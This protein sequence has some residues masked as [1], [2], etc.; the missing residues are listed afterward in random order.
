MIDETFVH[1]SVVCFGE[2]SIGASSFIGPGTVIYGPALIGDHVYIGANSVIGAAAED[3]SS[4]TTE[5]LI[6]WSHSGVETNICIKSLER[7]EKN[8][9]DRVVIGSHTIIRESCTIHS[10]IGK[11]TLIG[12]HCFIHS[13]SGIDHDCNL[14]DRVVL[15]PGVTLAGNVSLGTNCQIGLGAGV[16]QGV[17]VGPYAMVGMQAAVVRDCPP[18]GLCK[19][20][21]ARVSG[22]NTVRLKRWGLSDKIIAQLSEAVLEGRSLPFH[23]L[24]KD[25]SEIIEAWLNRLD[26]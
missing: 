26:G 16:H 9:K 1:S 22:A 8:P 19:G 10:G 11:P 18:L 24:P 17:S 6:A 14:E 23:L 15:A 12:K 3:A 25:K 4:D 21:P 7:R 2:V 20:V 5:S 13:R